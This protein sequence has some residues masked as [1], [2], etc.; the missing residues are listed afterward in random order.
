MIHTTRENWYNRSREGDSNLRDGERA[1]QSLKNFKERR[2]KFTGLKL[3]SNGT[4]RATIMP[5][6]ESFPYVQTGKVLP[7]SKKLICASNISAVCRYMR[8][9]SAMET[10]YRSVIYNGNA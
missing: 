7:Q 2:R 3:D 6:D 8:A 4:C 5:L 9:T 10:R 1:G